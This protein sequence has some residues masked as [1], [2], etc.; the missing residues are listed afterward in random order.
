MFEPLTLGKH[1]HCAKLVL[2]RTLA[3]EITGTSFVLLY[4][5]AIKFGTA[6]FSTESSGFTCSLLAKKVLFGFVHA[7]SWLIGTLNPSNTGD[8]LYMQDVVD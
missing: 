7:V 8:Y 1:K 5:F 6:L 4:V 2:P 3:G